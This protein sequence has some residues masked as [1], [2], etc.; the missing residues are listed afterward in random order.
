MV[1]PDPNLCVPRSEFAHRCFGAVAGQA[2]PKK[3]IACW[4]QVSE[5]DRA[6]PYSC[7]TGA[8]IT[9]PRSRR[10]HETQKSGSARE[11]RAD[12]DGGKSVDPAP[13]MLRR[14]NIKSMI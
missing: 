12:L 11:K 6:T 1:P 14:N 4:P 2:S 7:P 9:R 10:L 8:H 3:T 13:R 5:T